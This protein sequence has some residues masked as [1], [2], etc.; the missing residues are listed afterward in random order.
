MTVIIGCSQTEESIDISIH[1]S[2]NFTTKL[3]ARNIE[4]KKYCKIS[5]TTGKKISSESK[6][7]IPEYR[8][9]YDTSL[10]V[11]REEKSTEFSGSKKIRRKKSVQVQLQ[12]KRAEIA[13]PS[14]KVS[15]EKI[16]KKESPVKLPSQK[17]SLIQRPAST[18]R[19]KEM[20]SNLSLTLYEQIP[21][22]FLKHPELNALSRGCLIFSKVRNGKIYVNDLPV[23]LHTLK[24]ST[25][26]SEMRQALKAVNVDEFQNALKMFSKVKSGR[27]ATEDVAAV[28]ES[29]DI[30][31][32][33]EVLKD[34]LQHAHEDS[35]HTMDIGDIIFTLEELQRQYEDESPQPHPSKTTG[36]Q[37]EPDLKL[38]KRSS[39]TRRLSSGIISDSV[40]FQEPHLKIHDSKSKSPSLKSTTSLNKLLDKGDTSVSDHHIKI[41]DKRD[42]SISDRI[43][44]LDKRDSSISDRIKLLD[45]R[46]SSVISDRNKLL[47]KSDTSII[48]DR[49]KLLHISDTSIISDRQKLALKRL[50]STL[51]HV[52]KKESTVSALENVYEALT[53]LL[54]DYIS[55]EALQSALP[56][57][58]IA[59]SDED[60]QKIVP[61]LTQTD[62]GMVN[63]DDFLMAV[64][65]EHNFLDYDALNNVIEGIS[66]IQDEYVDYEDLDT[67]LQNFGVYLPKSE[68]QKIK[69]LLQVDG[70]KQVNIKEFIDTMLK[71][72]HP[73][74]DDLLLPTAIETL[75][76]LGSDQMDISQL[77]NTL[78]SL[79]SNLE[80]EEFL[81][82]VKLA[83]IDGDKVQL[84]DFSKVVKDMR[85]S[86][87]LKELQKIA[88]ALDSLEDEKIP[89]KNLEDFLKSLG[90]T[91]FKD[92]VDEILQSDI[93]SED[94]MVTVKECMEA[95]RDTSK[96][97]NFT[98]LKKEILSSSLKLPTVSEIIEAADILSKVEDG[99]IAI[100]DLERALKHLNINLTEED[101]KEAL[102]HC[103]ISD[104]MYVDL[105]DF[106]MK[107]KD[108]PSFKDS[109][110][111]QLLLAT[112]QV[113]EKDRIDV[114][115]LKTLLSNNDLH[116]AKA[117]LTEVLKHVPEDEEGKI[118]VDEFVNKFTDILRTLKSEP[119]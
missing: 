47:D 86:F 73:F 84:E 31:V 13:T 29:M 96:F 77:W 116:S 34:V 111:T 83:A 70:T 60:F 1:G 95:L 82:A 41:L 42:S 99:K 109:V 76:N 15:K 68:R 100:S 32:N 56:S 63:L 51:Q 35:Y 59:L 97:S 48:S 52:A 58:G 19:R 39:E 2:D 22:E 106:F 75:Q 11:Y 103:D 40:G 108:T 112:P 21:E 110:V 3:T 101:F 55:P 9:I 28:L 118:T 27:V 44:L 62:T 66:K 6:G 91:S 85:D 45:K 25:S 18:L 114:S 102:K 8:K 5:K 36:K 43:K 26:D 119:E 79:D 104:D 80:E 98:G 10:F 71:N 61:E 38:P 14:L 78:S 92:E 69:E 49:N 12:S 65:K 94:N 115:D 57:V 4:T 88:L 74:S 117:I 72:T 30:S 7:L 24:I 67:C 89:G 16:T 46:E 17:P 87:R 64:S 81:E 105:Q 33:P 54:E 93:A 23:V 20:P 113:L 37:D 107:V 53:K 90:I 50:S